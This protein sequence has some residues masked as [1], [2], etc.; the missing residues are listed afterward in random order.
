MNPE[1]ITSSR[2]TCP[3]ATCR[4]TTPQLHREQINL[5]SCGMPASTTD[6]RDPNP[7]RRGW[8][9]APGR[10]PHFPSLVPTPTEISTRAR[11]VLSLHTMRIELWPHRFIRSRLPHDVCYRARVHYGIKWLPAGRPSEW[12]RRSLC[13]ST[14]APPT[15][16]S[17]THCPAMNEMQSSINSNNTGWE[18]ADSRCLSIDGDQWLLTLAFTAPSSDFNAGECD[19]SLS[20]NKTKLRTF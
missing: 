19:C 13:T 7:A 5:C 8:Q 16:N 2:A 4:L 14:A 1:P 10:L 3:K 18:S 9:N 17:F 11:Q 20:V 12:V 6:Y 15:D